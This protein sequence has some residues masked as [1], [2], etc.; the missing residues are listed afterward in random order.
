MDRRRNHVPPVR[1]DGTVVARCG[2][3]AHGIGMVWNGQRGRL[4]RDV[5]VLGPSNEWV[6]S[7]NLTTNNLSDPDNYDALLQLFVDAASL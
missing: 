1:H 5:I 6:G 2:R 3:Q 4:L 7:F